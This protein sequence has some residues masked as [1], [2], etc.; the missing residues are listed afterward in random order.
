[1][2]TNVTIKIGGEAA[3]GIQTI[4]ALLSEVCLH[5]GLFIYAV[6]HSHSMNAV[7]P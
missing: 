7:R 1:M 4:G 3:Q 6:D 2:G 5:N